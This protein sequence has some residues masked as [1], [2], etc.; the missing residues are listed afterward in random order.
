MVIEVTP[1][2]RQDLIRV[3]MAAVRSDVD[4][5]INMAYKLDMPEHDISPAPIREAAHAIISIHLDRQLTQHQIHEVTY[6]L[7]GPFY[8]FPLRLPSSFVYI[9]RAGALIDGLRRAYYANL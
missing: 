6:Q 8:R 4:G 5:L 3:V 7:L 1:E 2:L 9:L